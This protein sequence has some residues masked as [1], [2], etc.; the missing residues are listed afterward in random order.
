MLVDARDD[1]I[2]STLNTC[3]K[4]IVDTYDRIVPLGGFDPRV[5]IGKTQVVHGG[6]QK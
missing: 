5:V 6:Y 2:A 4:R 3:D 1:S